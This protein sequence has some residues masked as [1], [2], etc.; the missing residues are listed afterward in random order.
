MEKGISFPFLFLF[1]AQ[2][3][4]PLAL[5]RTDF[6]I[7]RRG[8]C[9]ILLI[10]VLSGVLSLFD[11]FSG[12]ENEEDKEMADFLKSKLPRNMKTGM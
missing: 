3:G 2:R 9:L 1:Q 4:L 5:R 6:P 10:Y 7:R 11:I 12:R 8:M